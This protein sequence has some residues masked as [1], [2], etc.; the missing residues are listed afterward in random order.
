MNMPQLSLGFCEKVIFA[1]RSL[2]DGYGYT[3][4]KMNKFE[5][6]DLYARNKDFLISDSVITFTDTNGKLMA[7]KPDVTLSIVKNSRDTAGVQ[8]LYYNENVYR[9]S[10]GSQSFREIMQ[11]GLEC[12]GTID[13]YCLT[14]VLS[15]AARSL[16]CISSNCILDVSHLGLLSELMDSFGI[17]QG[18]K[19]GLF[20]FVGQKNLH[21]LT[22]SCRRIGVA[23]ERI[24]VLTEL[25]S[26]SGSV[27]AVLPRMTAL[28]TGRV[29]GETLDRFDR[30]LSALEGT[31]AES[32]LHLDFSV[33]DDF[34]YYNGI[35]FKG[36]IDG[37]PNS[38]LSGGQ[39]D[40]LMRKMHRSSGAIGFAVYMDLL[41]RLEQ[42]SREF[43][44]DVL[45][46]YDD[47]ADLQVLR[48]H[49]DALIARGNAV[50]VQRAVPE[51]VKYRKL[52]RLQGDQLE[53]LEDYA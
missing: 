32:V 19:A 23:E 40:E 29:N 33:V 16:L 48:R 13:D 28:L 2:Y 25:L 45:I 1:L 18:E 35:V 10:R 37:L 31:Q 51:Q 53:V 22:E 12:M 14:E 24:A 3:R 7:L 44:V 21:E 20:R 4:Y 34:H 15:L 6:Y 52:L 41:E 8:K 5:E 46:L 27:R 30:V 50:L 39:Y 47:H 9:I 26:L 49:A 43:D 38:I 11:V 42:R 17:P 36:F